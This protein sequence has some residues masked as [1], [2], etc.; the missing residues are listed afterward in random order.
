MGNTHLDPSVIY[1][2]DIYPK[3][4][5]L[6]MSRGQSL[7]IDHSGHSLSQLYKNCPCEPKMHFCFSVSG[8]GSVM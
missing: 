6:E 2:G 7:S 5:T 8:G 4:P 3:V 1:T